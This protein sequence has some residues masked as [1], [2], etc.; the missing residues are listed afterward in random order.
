MRP[1]P[2]S[3]AA[4]FALTATACGGG[5]SPAPAK[6]G[7]GPG[8][9]PQKSAA[10]A[11]AE[12]KAPPAPEPPP[13]PEGA[14]LLRKPDLYVQV[15]DPAHPCPKKLQAE[16]V[17]HCAGLKLGELKWRLP[18]REEAK[19]F[20]GAS[21]LQDLETFHW[22]QT[23]YAEDAAQVWVFDPKGGQETTLQKTRKPFVVRCVA[24]VP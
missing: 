5:S 10:P 2:L 4:L 11:K 12:V 14:V 8:K 19:R 6:A 17:T 24:P 3:F 18:E 7:E 21:E 20:R 13:A 1:L 22:T 9:A 16:G 23:P 15:C